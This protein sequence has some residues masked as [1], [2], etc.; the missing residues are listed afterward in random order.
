MT[1]L[2]EVDR[3]G[4]LL[5]PILLSLFIYYGFN[6]YPKA[7]I[8]MGDPFFK[9]FL[10][11]YTP[12]LSILEYLVYSFSPIS[13]VYLVSAVVSTYVYLRFNRPGLP[14]VATISYLAGD[15]LTPLFYSL[16][17]VPK[18]SILGKAGF[19]IHEPLYLLL[20]SIRSRSYMGIALSTAA[21]LP[22]Y[23]KYLDIPNL[24]VLFAV[25]LAGLFTYLVFGL[26]SLYVLP[27]FIEPSLAS[28]FEPRSEPR[29]PFTPVLGLS[30][31]L[32]L[33]PPINPYLNGGLDDF[34]RNNIGDD[35]VL[36]LTDDPTIVSTL[37]KLGIY[38]VYFDD[39]M[40]WNWSDREAVKPLLDGAIEEMLRLGYKYIVLEKPSELAYWVS[41]KH[42]KEYKYPVRE[43][44]SRFI[45]ILERKGHSGGEPYIKPIDFQW[46]GDLN[47]FYM[48]T[49]SN[50]SVDVEVIGDMIYI[51]AEEPYEAYLHF[52]VTD[53]G[54]SGLVFMVY[55]EVES[56]EIYRYV[57]G[58]ISIWESGVLPSETPIP[59]TLELGETDIIVFKVEADS[60]REV[61]LGFYEGG[62]LLD[63]SY[64]F[65]D[66]TVDEF[67][68]YVEI[69]YTYLVNGE[70]QP[71]YLLLLMLLT[72]L[73][74]FIEL[75]TVPRRE[76][77]ILDRREQGF[78]LYSAPIITY[79][80]QTRLLEVNWIGG[81]VFLL[82]LSIYIFTYIS[83]RRL[84][85]EVD[86]RVYTL[87]PL[88]VFIATMVKMLW[89]DYF[90][91]MGD[92][93]RN[94]ALYA[95]I[96]T[97]V[98]SLYLLIASLK[99]IGSKVALL[100]SLYLLLNSGAFISDLS[101]IDSPIFRA[102]LEINVVL[103]D[104]TLE[105]LGYTLEYVYVPAGY[106]MYLY[107][108]RLLTIVI[109][110]WPCAGVTGLFLYSSFASAIREVYSIPIK[111]Y[112]WV[113]VP[114]LIG[115]FLLNIARVDTILLLDV[116]YGVDAAELF[117]STLY[118]MVFLLWILLMWAMV[119]LLRRRLIQ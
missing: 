118:E 55:Q 115:T 7:L 61:K 50:V 69:E 83:P 37:H 95:A 72:P 63:V 92:H 32:L 98:F 38:T 21:L 102:I 29:Y 16:V 59:L 104:L 17:P 39:A 90:D 66:Y 40:D 42:F 116:Y 94:M 78:I 86:I 45:I 62:E 84:G 34:F 79:L 101:R 68:D 18:V 82:A 9:V 81:G 87:Y 13:I 8:Y 5:L 107:L 71:N 77:I 48:W 110:G 47:N 1:R 60:S 54:G 105:T 112:M 89:G 19:L 113:M 88:A 58:L 52:N 109:L 57:D 28:L 41:P 100:P 67:S 26:E 73:A 117:H 53:W 99:T 75:P 64:G 119:H 114:G 70:P 10:S 25:A 108:E 23:G 44:T 12:N 111:K 56:I 2:N 80:G 15:P 33:S 11:P 96:D 74:R 4:S 27:A 35:A 43:D 14:L 85:D 97:T 103:V 22:M 6:I 30:L 3:Y 31:L 76:P 65:G 36:L 91:L 24:H 49:W 20:H 106:A 93:W 51:D 46:R